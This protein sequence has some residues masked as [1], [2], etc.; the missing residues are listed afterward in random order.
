MFKKYFTVLLLWVKYYSR[1]RKSTRQTELLSQCIVLT[2]LIDTGVL[3]M[4]N[5]ISSSSCSMISLL[6]LK[7]KVLQNLIHSVSKISVPTPCCTYSN[8]AFICYFNELSEPPMTSTLLDTMVQ[9]PNDILT[10]PVSISHR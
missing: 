1:Q 7:A 8:E 4:L 9:F 6:P 5:I 10:S 3:S 2:I